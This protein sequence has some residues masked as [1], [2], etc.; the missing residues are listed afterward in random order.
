MAR[1]FATVCIIGC[2][3]RGV[4]G[5]DAM[6]QSRYKGAQP[7]QRQVGGPLNAAG[8]M[9]FVPKV[10]YPAMHAQ[11]GTYFPSLVDQPKRISKPQASLFFSP[12]PNQVNRNVLPELMQSPTLDFGN[13]GRRSLNSFTP[14][15][16]KVKTRLHSDVSDELPN[17][18]RQYSKRSKKSRVSRR[19][20]NSQ[21]VNVNTR[22]GGGA[23]DELL[24]KL[25]GEKMQRNY[26]RKDE[27]ASNKAEA[28]LLSQDLAVGAPKQHK[29]KHNYVQSP[30]FRLKF[31]NWIG[32]VGVR[33]PDRHDVDANQRMSPYLNDQAG[34]F[35]SEGRAKWEAENAKISEEQ[36]RRNLEMF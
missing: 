10:S 3:W 34:S 1:L 29:P 18:D 6:K 12:A 32:D 15:T 4:E 14:Q 31:D 35:D 33:R 13:V 17:V 30:D 2:V 27:L 24:A 22:V 9:R 16:V 5:M 11:V 28:N 36:N 7:L 20:I 23:S 8:G 25:A 26:A 19:S 21:S